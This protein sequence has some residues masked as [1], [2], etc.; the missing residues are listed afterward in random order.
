M[1]NLW[2]HP[3]HKAVEQHFGR[4]AMFTTVMNGKVGAGMAL[5]SVS[6][7]AACA[8]PGTSLSSKGTLVVDRPEDL[9]TLPDPT[10]DM[11]SEL[12][13]RPDYAQIIVA[14]G[15]ACP[16]RAD[17][18]G[19]G[20]TASIPSTTMVEEDGCRG[21]V[22]VTTV[23]PGRDVGPPDVPTEEDPGIVTDPPA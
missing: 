18:F 9:C 4:F 13:G 17:L 11:V 6:L 10:P 5:L 22:G 16:E 23:S 14:L 3:V 20:A 21:F 19:I 8:T 1:A 15:R 2:L 7:L 12:R